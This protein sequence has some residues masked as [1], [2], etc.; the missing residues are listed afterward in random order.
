M[1]CCACLGR[2]LQ[3]HPSGAAL[4]VTGAGT[5][6]CNGYFKESGQISGRTNYTK[7]NDDGSDFKWDGRNVSIWWNGSLWVI[8]CNGWK[9]S[10]GRGIVGDGGDEGRHSNKADTE[11]PPA[12]GWRVADYGKA[13]APSV[14]IL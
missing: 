2:V 12:G 5:D 7:V 9:Y 10:C 1:S 8:D 4:K 11:K 3:V 13:P 14:K 6:Y